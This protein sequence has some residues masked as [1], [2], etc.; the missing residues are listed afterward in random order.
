MN[1]FMGTKVLRG[2]HDQTLTRCRD[3]EKTSDQL[4]SHFVLTQGPKWNQKC[5]LIYVQRFPPIRPLTVLFL[6]CNHAFQFGFHLGSRQLHQLQVQYQLCIDW[7]LERSTRFLSD[8]EPYE[9]QKQ[10]RT[11]SVEIFFIFNRILSVLK[12]VNPEGCVY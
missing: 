3:L 8:Q 6:A 4:P 7:N 9:N 1:V 2:I 12:S 10:G 5:S 11:Q